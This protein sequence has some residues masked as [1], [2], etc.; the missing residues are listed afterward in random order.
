M[1]MDMAASPSPSLRRNLE[2][3]V[4]PGATMVRTTGRGPDRADLRR[5]QALPAGSAVLMWGSSRSCRE[6]ADLA[7]VEIDREFLPVPRGRAPLYLI[8]N[9]E[10]CIDYFC[11]TLLTLPPR[12]AWFR[13]LGEPLIALA[14]AARRSPR[15][16]AMV[17]G[18]VLVGRRR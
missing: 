9:A 10:G 17:R 8:E 16:A 13:P 6:F 18:R 2:V 5:V 12:S 11:S 14:R 15:L 3:L 7:G 1:I 4:A